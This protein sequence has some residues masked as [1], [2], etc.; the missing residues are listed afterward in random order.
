MTKGRTNG[1][2]GGISKSQKDKNRTERSHSGFAA[3]KNEKEEES[4]FYIM[5]HRYL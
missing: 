3:N 2:K 5:K 4:R 1:E